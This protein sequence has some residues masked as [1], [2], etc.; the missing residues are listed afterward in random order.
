MYYLDRGWIWCQMEYI[1]VRN[2]NASISDWQYQISGS[3]SIRNNLECLIQMLYLRNFVCKILCACVLIEKSHLWSITQ[4]S[5]FNMKI[6]IE[7]GGSMLTYPKWLNAVYV[8][9][10]T[11]HHHTKISAIHMQIILIYAYTW[12]FRVTK[13]KSISIFCLY[14]QIKYIKQ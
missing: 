9:K 6:V 14:I 8:P 12:C 2:K 13:N 11:C 1:N 10:A 3:P 4:I 5:K 7:N